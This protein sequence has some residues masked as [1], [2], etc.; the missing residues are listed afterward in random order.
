MRE[1]ELYY[2]AHPYTAKDKRAETANF[3]LC[4]IRSAKLLKL[5]YRIYAPICHTHPIHM[6]WPDFLENDERDLWISLDNLIINKTLFEGII[7]AP[8]WEL[9]SGCQGEKQLFET[10]EKQILLYKDIVPMGV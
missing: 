8:R 9:S 7:L 1:E 3:N 2:F 10:Q 4:C 5:G 6:A